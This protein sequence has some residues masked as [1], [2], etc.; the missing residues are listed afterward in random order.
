MKYSMLLFHRYVFNWAKDGNS[1]KSLEK[2]SKSSIHRLLSEEEKRHEIPGSGRR[3]RSVQTSVE[4]TE[5]RR[6]SDFPG[7]KV[8]T[9]IPGPGDPES[10]HVRNRC[11]W[12]GITGRYPPYVTVCLQ[13]PS[14]WKPNSNG[15]K[16]NHRERMKKGNHQKYR[17][18]N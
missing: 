7:N 14:S 15:V 12:R 1:G 13:P 5:F 9:S 18:L 16:E 11:V 8:V 17:L 6:H 2:A 10:G 4:S 3:S